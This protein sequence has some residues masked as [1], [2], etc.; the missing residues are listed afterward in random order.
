M[1]ARRSWTDVIQT[2][3]KHKCQPRLLYPAKLSIN[4]DGEI[5]IFHDENIFT[6]YLSTNPALQRIINGKAQH[7]EPDLD[8][9]WETQPEYSKYRG[10]CQQQTTELRTGL[11]LKES[12]KELEELKGAWDPIWTTMPSNQSFQGLSH[13]LKTI[14]GLTL[15]SDLIS[16]SEYPSTIISGR[17]SPGSC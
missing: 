9:S 17:G 1:K 3:R 5:K 11:P 16:S 13:Y 14:H 12:E 7:K 2:L 15:N 10:E 4:I 6:Q 8:R